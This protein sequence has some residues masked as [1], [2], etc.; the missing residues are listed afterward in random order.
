MP[1][2]ILGVISHFISNHYFI[3]MTPLPP[4]RKYVQ[5]WHVGQ[6]IE[7]NKTI[8]KP[9]FSLNT[10]ANFCIFLEKVT[11]SVECLLHISF[12]MKIKRKYDCNFRGKILSRPVAGL[13]FYEM[14]LKIRPTFGSITPFVFRWSLRFSQDIKINIWWPTCENFTSIA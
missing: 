13:D 3:T 2:L 5:C 14:L 11:L 1:L 8:L 4:P 7:Y 10:W 6:L 9:I 12:S